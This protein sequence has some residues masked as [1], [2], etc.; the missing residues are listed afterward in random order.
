MDSTIKKECNRRRFSLRT[1]KTYLF[2]I[3]K[4]L[5]FCKRDLKYISKKDAREF[6]EKLSEKDVA[7]S[8]L[9]VYHMAIK[10]LLEEILNKR[11]KLN[12]KYSKV[13]KTLPIV[14]TKEEVKKLIDSIKNEKHKLIAKLMYSAG[15]RVTELCKLKVEDLEFEKNYGRVRKGKGNK[16]RL[17]II[18]NNIKDQLKNFIKNNDLNYWILQGNKKNYISQ[19][20]VQEII[21]QATKKA[22]I[23]K[24]VHAHTLRHSFATHLIEN[25][26]DVASVQS[27]LG[28][29]SSNTTMIYV[30]IASPNMINVK[31]PLDD[32]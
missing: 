9:N 19:K 5:N 3:H 15:L 10:F 31:S 23:K 1:I 7:G 21:K 22:C 16:D 14:L 17:F 8:T 11:M 6:L 2:C 27:L 26:Y 32:L 4:F 18:A 20:A 24:K 30:H 29:N 12:I 13:P 25:G 28:H